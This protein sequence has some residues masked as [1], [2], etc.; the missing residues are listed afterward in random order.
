LISRAQQLFG[1]HGLTKEPLQLVDRVLRGRWKDASRADAWRLKGLILSAQ[2]RHV[3]AA[4]A[5]RKALATRPGDTELELRLGISLIQ[6]GKL[7][8]GVDLLEPI[9]SRRL[10]ARRQDELELE[11]VIEFCA[12]ALHGL[13]R[14]S[15]ARSM[16]D[17]ALRR[18]RDPR[19]RSHLLR[20]RRRFG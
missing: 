3:E 7:K 1:F 14:A 4:A 10:S 15:E 2:D 13:G 5:L 18:M 19:L 9:A 20:K 11:L 6:A 8:A 12:E 17:K 16:V